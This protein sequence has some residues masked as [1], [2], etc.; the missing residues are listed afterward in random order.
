MGDVAT[1]IKISPLVFRKR[2]SHACLKRLEGEKTTTELSIQFNNNLN[3]RHEALHENEQK[4]DLCV[5]HN[6]CFII[7]NIAPMS[8]T[9]LNLVMSLK[10]GKEK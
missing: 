2:K 7:L 9:Q 4:K 3:I 6:V 10:K 5:F 8:Q 1:F